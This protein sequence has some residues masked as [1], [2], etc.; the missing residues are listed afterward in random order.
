MRLFKLP[1]FER[2]AA[3]AGINDDVL[4]SVVAHMADGRINANLGGF[5]YKQRVPRPGEG[6]S[7][8]Y[9]V[10]LFYREGDRVFFAHGFAKSDRPNIS[11]RELAALKLQADLYM[12]FTDTQLTTLLRQGKLIEII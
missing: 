10:L 8:G 3:K 1:A 9:R 12:G 6:K 7:G 2:F 11:R 5:V 4:K